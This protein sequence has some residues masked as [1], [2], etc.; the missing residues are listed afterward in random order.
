MPAQTSA[1]TAAVLTVSD[2]SHRGTRQDASGPAVTATLQQRGFNIVA[3]GVVP[4]E[5]D[6]I[7]RELIRLCGLAQ[8]VV[9]TGGTGIAARDVT[10][11]ATLAVCDRTVP[12]IAE[13]IG[14]AHV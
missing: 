1:P 4:D 6:A 3:T 8:L 5:R 2:S 7:E 11:E 10:P 14:R 12:G 9:T 13:Q